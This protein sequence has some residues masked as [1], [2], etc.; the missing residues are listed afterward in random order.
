[1]LVAT[2]PDGREAARAAAGPDGR[3]EMRLPPG[4]YQ[5]VPQPVEGL[6]GTPGPIEFRVSADPGEVPQ[7]LD[8]SYD[9]G[10]R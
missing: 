6:M 7:R 8:V 9:T 4:A 5:L 10:I 3:Y 1:V 2:A